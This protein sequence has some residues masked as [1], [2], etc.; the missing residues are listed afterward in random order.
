MYTLRAS[1][2]VG[3]PCMITPLSLKCGTV[4]IVKINIDVRAT[5]ACGFVVNV[6]TIIGL[7]PCNWLFPISNKVVAPKWSTLAPIAAD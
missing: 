5:H 1:T 7:F 4:L 3:Y 6:L 2:T